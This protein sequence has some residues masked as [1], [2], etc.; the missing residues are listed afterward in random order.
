MQTLDYSCF[1]SP[2][3]MDFPDYLLISEGVETWMDRFNK[4]LINKKD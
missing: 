3:D 1:Y 4:K 2:S